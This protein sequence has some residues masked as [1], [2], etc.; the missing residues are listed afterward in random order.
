MM[1]PPLLMVA[2]N[3]WRRK[4]QVKLGVLIHAPLAAVC[5]TMVLAEMLVWYSMPVHHHWLLHFG[6]STFFIFFASYHTRL[7]YG[8]WKSGKA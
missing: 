3:N 8:Y 5:A 7:A 1:A 2:G 6:W 4:M